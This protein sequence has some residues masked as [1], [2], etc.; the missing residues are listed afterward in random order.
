MITL[1]NGGEK[2]YEQ[3]LSLLDKTDLHEEKMR[4]LCSLGAVKSEELINRVLKLAL[5]VSFLN[6]TY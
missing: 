5:S 2:E 4:I 6:V 3:L 1:N